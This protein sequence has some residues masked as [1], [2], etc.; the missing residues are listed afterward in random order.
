M[1]FQ[2]YKRLYLKLRNVCTI[3]KCSTIFSLK[4][5]KSVPHHFHDFFLQKWQFEHSKKILW[6]VTHE[7]CFGF[8]NSAQQVPHTLITLLRV[9]YY[10]P[11]WQYKVNTADCC[12]NGISTYLSYRNWQDITLCSYFGRNW[13]GPTISRSTDL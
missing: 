5:Q 6:N 9:P 3:C 12:R 1:I 4:V 11:N 7:N 2:K 8:F 10:G 13:S